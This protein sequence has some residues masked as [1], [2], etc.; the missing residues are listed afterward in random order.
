[1]PR[2]ASDLDRRIV[3]AARKRFLHDGVDGASLRSI[4]RDAHTNIGM[5]YYYFPTKDDLFLAVVEDIYPKLLEDLTR[6]LAPG[7]PVE[8]RLRG[9][10]HRFSRL[11]NDE[12]EVVR[13][14]IREIL[15]SSSRLQRIME[16][17]MRGH[18]PHV[19]STLAEGV[20]TGVLDSNVQPGVMLVATFVTCV[21]PQVVRRLAGPHTLVP[22]PEGEDLADGLVDVLLHGVAKRR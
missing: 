8:E 18:A 7:R 20:Q 17:F 15:A 2:P 11:S 6:A 13:I 1:M 4:A 19:I 12:L 16:R 9:L 22:L 3:R 14:I 10:F 5:I 21:F